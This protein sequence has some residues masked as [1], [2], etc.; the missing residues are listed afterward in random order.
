MAQT[1][2]RD[3]RDSDEPSW[4]RCRVLGFLDTAYFDDVWLAHPASETGWSLV[5]AHG[6]EIVG[7]CEASLAP[8][9]ATVDTIAVHPDYRRTGL[10]SAL[11]KELIRRLKQNEIGQVDAWTRD[12]PGTLAWYRARGFDARYRYLHVYAEGAEEV[13]TAA[14]V[15][16]GLIARF[17]FFHADTQDAAVESDL[18]RQFTRVHACH[19]FVKDL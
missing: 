10:G 18:R 19:R 5:A 9:G 13:A 11:L 7:V 8:H 1:D 4:L 16:P 2:I 15:P 17:A 6:G 3:Y 14:T 12:D